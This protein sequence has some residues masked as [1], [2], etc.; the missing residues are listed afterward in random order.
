M[1]HAKDNSRNAKKIGDIDPTKFWEAGSI[2]GKPRFIVA[3]KSVINTKSDFG[4][5]LLC[6][7]LT[8]TAGHAC[9]FK[10]AFCYVAAMM[11]KNR[12]LNIL[13]KTRGLNY[14]DVVVEIA[15]AASVARKSLTRHGLPRFADPNDNR[16]IYASPLVDVAATMDQVN[17]TVEICRAI[18][19]LTHWQIR[20]L[21]KSTLLLQVAKQLANHKDRIIFGFSTGTLDDQITKSFEIGTALVSKRLTAL[22]QLQDEG[23]RTFGMLCPILPPADYGRFAEQVAQSIDVARTEH[24]WAEVLNSRGDSMLAT[25][26]A[27][28]HGGW[29]AEAE[30]LDHVAHN[31]DAWE[32]YAEQTFLTLAKI[33]PPAKL[34]F[35]QYVTANDYGRWKIYEARGAVL[36]GK[37]AKK[38]AG[39]NLA[40]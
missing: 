26:K 30:R 16:V 22:K 25:I 9:T 35:L 21:S 8:F 19:E 40:H 6:D 27:L 29:H 7:G 10:C 39:N 32:M 36:L 24:V 12:N 28:R 18:L 31:K 15:D 37:Y 3:S 17:T 1:K 23:F 38:M 20:L 33:V 2:A 4:H 5:K 34:R 11:R 14:E 13:L